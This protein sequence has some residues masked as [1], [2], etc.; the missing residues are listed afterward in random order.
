MVKKVKKKNNSDIAE[1]SIELV[2]KFSNFMYG[3]GKVASAIATTS[4]QTAEML[5]Q[6]NKVKQ[7]IKEVYDDGSRRKK[8][9]AKKS[10]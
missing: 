6:A 7:K 10:D 3:L 8:K 2:N 4:Q 9:S 5:D 1:E